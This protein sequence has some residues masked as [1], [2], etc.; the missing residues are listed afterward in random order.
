MSTST[1]RIKSKEVKTWDDII[2]YSIQ[3]N[4]KA[5]PSYRKHLACELYYSVENILDNT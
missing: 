2:Q 5:H 3:H 1:N 4:F